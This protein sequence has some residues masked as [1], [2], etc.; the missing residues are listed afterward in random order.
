MVTIIVSSNLEIFIPQFI[1]RNNRYQLC[2]IIA[3][4]NNQLFALA[5]VSFGFFQW[6]SDPHTFSKGDGCPSLTRL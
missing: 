2:E 6:R 3:N 5:L 1:C 4:A